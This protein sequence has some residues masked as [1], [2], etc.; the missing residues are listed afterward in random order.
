MIKIEKSLLLEG[1]DDPKHLILNDLFLDEKTFMHCAE[2]C[3][4]PRT[5][6]NHLVMIHGFGGNM[7]TYYRML[8]YLKSFF[9]IT[10]LDIPG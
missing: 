2:I 7:Y 8:K 4:V 1:L 3:E 9:Y 6:N 10:L 5:K